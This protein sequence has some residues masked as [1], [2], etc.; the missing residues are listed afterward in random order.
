MHWDWD[1]QFR[2]VGEG[3][4]YYREARSIFN[5]NKIYE[6]TY[7]A[8]QLFLKFLCPFHPLTSILRCEC[9]TDAKAV[10]KFWIFSLNIFLNESVK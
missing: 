5:N 8:Y 7:N 1:I 4:V 10:V 9:Y 6:G 3:V 2:I